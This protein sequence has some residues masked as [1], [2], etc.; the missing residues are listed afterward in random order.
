M[1][2]SGSRT[3]PRSRGFDGIINAAISC[4]FVFS[5]MRH[6]KAP[7][8]WLYWGR[9]ENMAVCICLLQE[10]ENRRMNVRLVVLLGAQAN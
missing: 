1:F 6:L 7:E 8:T 4:N 9:E 10:K 5:R 2:S 3:S